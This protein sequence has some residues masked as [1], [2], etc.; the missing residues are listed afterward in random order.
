MSVDS[1]WGSSQWRVWESVGACRVRGDG[2]PGALV[3]FSDVAL[4]L[5]TLTA[6]LEATK[7]I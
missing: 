4:S 3:L 7:A 6:C 1:I 2:P 5:Y